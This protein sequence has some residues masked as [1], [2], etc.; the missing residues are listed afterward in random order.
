MLE[1][2]VKS[3]NNLVLRDTANKNGIGARM[4]KHPAADSGFNKPLPAQHRVA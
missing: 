4:P 2:A 3:A 1:W